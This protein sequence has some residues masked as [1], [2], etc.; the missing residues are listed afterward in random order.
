[1]HCDALSVTAAGVAA[2]AAAPRPRFRPPGRYVPDDSRDRRQ[3]AGAVVDFEQH[4]GSRRLDFGIDLVG[5]DFEDHVAGLDR[6]ADIDAP[7]ADS[8]ICN[9]FAHIGHS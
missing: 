5:R 7:A 3:F 4:A 6:L 2:T 1:V 9:A 8:D